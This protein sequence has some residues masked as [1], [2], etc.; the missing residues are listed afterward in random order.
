MNNDFTSHQELSM[1][2]ETNDN[3]IKINKKNF[4]KVISKVN[5]LLLLLFTIAFFSSIII[6]IL[7]V[8]ILFAASPTA[9][10]LDDP[11]FILNDSLIATAN[12]FL[13][14][15][16]ALFSAIFICKGFF[17]IKLRDLFIG[18]NKIPYYS[19]NGSLAC[20]GFGSIGLL[21]AILTKSFFG[22]FNLETTMADLS[23]PS[24]SLLIIVNVAYI[25]IIG[26]IFEEIIF[27]GFIF[28]AIKPL[29]SSFAIIF[30]SIL[31]GIFHGN[32]L[33]LFPAMLMGT[34]LAY[35]TLKTHSIIP[36]II[37][38]IFNNSF[39]Y[40]Q[41]YIFTSGFI[42]DNVSN[43]FA[44]LITVLTIIIAVFLIFKN[45]NEI[46]SVK[47]NISLYPISN[48]KKY[49]YSFTS[50]PFILCIIYFLV[51][52]ISLFLLAS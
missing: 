32:L 17:K 29:G 22:L 1:D 45:L 36:A 27:R 52:C 5:L 44:I 15:F 38:H 4:K 11:S 28:K 21:F 50:I 26:P 42:N 46:K 8:I 47:N 30:S 12:M 7:S 31:F 35:I 14:P 37:A 23:I 9:I 48:T 16:I 49:L 25:C 39:R 10:N 2:V 18:K 3:N 19:T 6:V 41:E 33:Q 43:V 34:V 40:L 51:N 20:V 13:P 24:S